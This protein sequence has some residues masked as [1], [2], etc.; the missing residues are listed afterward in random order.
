MGAFSK[1]AFA[2]IKRGFRLPRGHR[3]E[4]FRQHTRTIDEIKKRE[5]NVVLDVGANRGFFSE[6]LRATGYDGLILAFEPVR[7]CFDELA[8]RAAGDPRWRVFNC[9]LGERAGEIG[10]N[11]VTVGNGELVL[12]SALKPRMDLPT[13]RVV[14]PV[15]TVRD[16]LDAEL[17]GVADPR[18]FLKMDTQGY[19]L[20]VFKGAAN[21]PEIKLLLSEVSA[22]ATY[23]DMPL[24]PEVLSEYAAA[25]FGLLD[26][27]VCRDAGTDTIG[28]MDAL[29]ARS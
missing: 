17:A 12:S 29:L 18:V 19:D 8:Q 3:F 28:E 22:V 6:H 20:N 4:T 25:G 24:Y 2:L 7:E 13:R 15:R 23:D 11:V 9:A 10:F 16:V 27:F 1:G 5:V 21:A 14:V 26:L